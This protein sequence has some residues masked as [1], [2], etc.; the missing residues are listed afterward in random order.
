MLKQIF[1]TVPLKYLTKDE[2][3]GGYGPGLTYETG[4]NKDLVPPYVERVNWIAGIFTYG[5]PESKSGIGSTPNSPRSIMLMTTYSTR[6]WPGWLACVQQFDMINGAYVQRVSMDSSIASMALK[7]AIQSRSGRLFVING[8]SS[9]LEEFS[10]NIA[11]DGSISVQYNDDTFGGLGGLDVGSIRAHDFAGL[12][13]VGICALDDSV[14]FPTGNIVGRFLVASGEDLQIF[15]YSPTGTIGTGSLATTFTFPTAIAALALEGTNHAYVL[16][17]DGV[18]MLVDYAT[19][20]VL[21]V[22]RLPPRASNASYGNAGTTIKMNWDPLYRRLL[23]CDQTPDNPDGT[24][25]TKVIGYR[26]V[27]QMT[28][29]TT[30]IPLRVPRQ[31]RTI[32]VFVQVVGDMNEGIGGGIVTT[33]VFGDGSLVGIPLTDGKGRSF[34]NILCGVPGSPDFSSPVASPMDS[35]DVFLGDLDI[36]VKCSVEIPPDPDFPASGT[37]PPPIEVTT[38]P[39]LAVINGSGSGP[40]NTGST[41]AIAANAPVA[42]KVFYRWTGATVSSPLSSSTTLIMPASNVVVTATYIDIG[43]TLYTLNV[44]RGSGDGSYQAGDMVVISADTPGAG[45]VFN[46]WTGATVADPTLAATTITMPAA[47]ATVTATYLV[48]DALGSI[49]VGWDPNPGGEDV[50]GYVVEWGTAPD[51]FD[52]SRDAGDVFDYTITGLMVGTTY[53]ISIEAYNAVGYSG[54]AMEVVGPAT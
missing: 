50:L 28:R 19:K 46:G 47:D 3:T 40:H 54:E 17:A 15:K 4:Y 27:P 2:Y 52:H 9:A 37:P 24:S 43:V 38:L 1:Q 35:P 30:P 6:Y 39:N 8:Y 48:V 31:G 45:E 44:V 33:H 5:Y 22:A 10:L 23:I 34:I 26:L 13:S 29:I 12:S 51:V 11:L 7:G 16:L 25:T 20:D 36:E 49:H 18:L 53:Y 21:G 14:D 41:V 32:P 42:G